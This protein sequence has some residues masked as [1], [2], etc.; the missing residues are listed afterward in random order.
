M[1]SGYSCSVHSDAVLEN[2]SASFAFVK[3]IRVVS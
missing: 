3:S 2:R 1:I